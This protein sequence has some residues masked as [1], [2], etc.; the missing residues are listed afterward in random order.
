[1]CEESRELTH[2]S[3]TAAPNDD[4]SECDLGS[5]HYCHEEREQEGPDGDGCEAKESDAEHDDVGR[6][7]NSDDG[8]SNEYRQAKAKAVT[9]ITLGKS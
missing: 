3:S 5:D 9:T 8:Q 7:H 2:A 1:M 4:R 6:G